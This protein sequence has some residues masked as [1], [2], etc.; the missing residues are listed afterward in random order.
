MMSCNRNKNLAAFL[1]ITFF[2][3]QATFLFSQTLTQTIRGVVVDA[4]SKAPIEF[5]GV[6][7]LNSDTNITS[8]TD[9]QGKFRLAKVS[10]G[11]HALKF[12]FI[13][14]DDVVLQNI[15]VT[16]GK[17]VVLNVEMREKLLVGKEVE[18]VAQK[19]K[20][21]TNNDLVTNSGRSFNSEETER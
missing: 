6:K 13:G 12:S 4:D 1:F 11:R 10:V 18:I 20:T 17:E 9:A 21:K 2:A 8:A 5:V 7:V 15:I 19:D 3:T 16:S 14:Y